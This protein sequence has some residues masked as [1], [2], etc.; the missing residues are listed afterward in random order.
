MRRVAVVALVLA[1][2]G[3]AAGY[4]N[5]KYPYGAPNVPVSL[6]KCMRANGVSSFPDPRDGGF[7]GGMVVESSGEMVV[8][9]QPLAG[10]AVARAQ[11][12]CQEYFP[13]GA[14]PPLS[15]SQ[16]EAAVAHAVCMRS[17]GLPNFPDPSFNGPTKQLAL[18]PGLDPDSPAFQ[19]AARA[20][21]LLSR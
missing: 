18:G 10:P 20:C 15:E 14:P 8:M 21:G 7:P 16:R 5:P 1:G 6:S 3:S 19:R 13:H 2:C 12:A 4:H 9:G 11:K 17:H